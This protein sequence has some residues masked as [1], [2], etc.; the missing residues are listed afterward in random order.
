MD[1]SDTPEERAKRHIR[2]L[3]WLYFWLLLIE[4]ALRKWVLPNYSNP[5]L[6]I[7]DPVLIAIY[8]LAIPARV[9]SRNKWVAWVISLLVIGF[10]S[11]LTTLVELWPYFPTTTIAE[12]AGYGFRSNFFHLPLIFV[13]ASVLR[14]EDVK[15][16]G[17]WALLLLVPM[18]VLMVAQFGAAPDAFL[19]RAP[20]GE[21]EV[22]MS[23]LGKVRTAGTFSFVVGV[24]A[25]FSLAA[26]YLVWALLKPGLY[27]SWLLTIAGIALFVGI[28]VSGSRLTVGACAVVVASLVLVV[29]LR[30]DA[31]NRFGHALIV[32]LVLWLVVSRLPVFHEGINVMTTRF[33]EVAEA[34]DQ[35]VARGLVA[36]FFGSFG[37][38]FFV[39]PKAPLLGYG[40]GIGT[41][42][43]AKFLTGRSGFL[44][45]EG[46]WARIFLES[47]PVLGI[48]YVA[49]RCAIVGWI[50]WLCVR[51]VRLGNLL[52]LLLFSSS[53]LPMINGQFGQPTI[54]GF[55]VF[56]T[57]LA[58]AAR[59]DETFV[60]PRPALAASTRGEPVA[61]AVRGRSVYADRLHGPGTP[62]GQSN[63]SAD[64]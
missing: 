8:L 22:M 44:L 54:L 3:I 13:M 61:K 27:K 58:L 37:D 19:N 50:G 2:R 20:G 52:P 41:N 12:V 30:P 26:G 56:T 38:A 4:G 10:L 33:A 42:A 35:S 28:A 47:G 29:I 48:A 16:F 62:H 57:G 60:M 43:G 6:L 39:L 21:G 15:R 14:P 1:N 9:F 45:T 49:W 53:F 11:L 24:A 59:N 23:A 17:W 7:R 55:T 36:R 25:Y 32:I 5:L 64:R 40:L 34:S 31:V 63:G 51:S 18:S 46:E